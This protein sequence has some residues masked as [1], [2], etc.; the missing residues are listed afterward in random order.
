[1]EDSIRNSGTDGKRDSREA[2]ELKNEEP[3]QSKITMSEEDSV[4]LEAFEAMQK[5]SG[6][7]GA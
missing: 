2:P 7:S 4:L 6:F 3:E 1:M 5:Q